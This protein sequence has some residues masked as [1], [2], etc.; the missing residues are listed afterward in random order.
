[1]NGHSKKFQPKHI[2][3]ITSLS[4][5]P[6]VYE[7][8]IVRKILSICIVLWRVE[9]KKM[10]LECYLRY[11]KFKKHEQFKVLTAVSTIQVFWNVCICSLIRNTYSN[12]SWCLNLQNQDNLKMKALESFTMSKSNLITQHY[13]PKHLNI[14]KTLPCIFA[15]WMHHQTNKSSN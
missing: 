2:T 13:I 12:R 1:V 6:L 4:N 10:K 9:R 3:I 5:L 7:T 8:V 14:H 11:T 15:L